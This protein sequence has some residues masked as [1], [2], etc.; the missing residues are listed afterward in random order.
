MF[1]EMMKN[2][3]SLYGPTLDACQNAARF[4]TRLVCHQIESANESAQLFADRLRA[5]A[6][7][8]SVETLNR[9]LEGLTEQYA[10]NFSQRLM[11]IQSLWGQML[12]QSTG[13]TTPSEIYAPPPS[14][15]RDSERHKAA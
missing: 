5:Y 12:V 7:S 14:K 1:I 13:A 4:Q 3:A 2:A 11:Q 15:H 6:E 9:R 8:D 10:R